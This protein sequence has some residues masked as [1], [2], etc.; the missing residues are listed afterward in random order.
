MTTIIMIRH[1]ES[2]TNRKTVFT[3]NLN[4]NLTDKG[5]HQAKLA[6][7]YIID[8]YTV[9]KI[10]AS[11]LK[12]AYAT[13]VPVADKLGIEII[14]SDQLR[15]INGGEWENKTYTYIKEAYPE[16]YGL[17]L[18]DVGNA[19]CTGGESAKQLCDRVMKKLFEIAEENDGKTVLIATHAT[20]IRAFQTMCE[21]GTLD[22]MKNVP[23]VPNSSI[24]VAEYE[25]GKF[26]LKVI[27]ENSYLNDFATGFPTGTV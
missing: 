21:H 18:S 19:V 26:E 16:D 25:N 24:T 20:P 23:W 27:G 17:W 1:G 3:G 5:L 2:E 9:D 13:A 22:E 15:E 14:T 10:Y 8:N 7:E 12:R 6:G 4:P 11:D